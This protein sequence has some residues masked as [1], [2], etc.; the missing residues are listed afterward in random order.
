M[1]LAA[2][3]LVYGYRE[4]IIGRDIALSLARGEVLALLGPM[5]AARPRC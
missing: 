2:F 3:D 5:A 1:S 4:R